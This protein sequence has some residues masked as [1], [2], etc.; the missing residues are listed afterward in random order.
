MGCLK[1]KIIQTENELKGL[2]KIQCEINK[3]YFDLHPNGYIT[4]ALRLKLDLTGGRI[5]SGFVQG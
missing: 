4:F 2:P 1:G 3:G 5:S